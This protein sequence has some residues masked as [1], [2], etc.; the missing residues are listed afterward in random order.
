M[1]WDGLLSKEKT[2]YWESK[3]HPPTWTTTPVSVPVDEDPVY[4]VGVTRD[5]KVTLKM[6]NSTLTMNDLGVDQLIR[7]LRAA[8]AESTPDEEQH[9][10]DTATP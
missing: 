9:V 2:K 3:V 7:M 5:G 10:P 1:F 4:Q 8:G 6:G